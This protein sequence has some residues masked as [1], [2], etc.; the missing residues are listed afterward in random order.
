MG[1]RQYQQN[2]AQRSAALHTPRILLSRSGSSKSKKTISRNTS[3]AE[4]S[5]T[6]VST[7]TGE[8]STQSSGSVVVEGTSQN[9]GPED[10]EDYYGLGVG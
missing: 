9:W 2:C 1:Y 8:V 7:G 6:S 4:K 10:D 3:I 5:I